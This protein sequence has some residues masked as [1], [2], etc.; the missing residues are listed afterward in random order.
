MTSPLNTA[1]V[2]AT[3]TIAGVRYSYSQGVTAE[4]WNNGGDDFRD[5]VRAGARS[6][7]GQ[8]LAEQLPVTL[9]DPGQEPPTD[10]QPPQPGYLEVTRKLGHGLIVNTAP[11]RIS[12][13]LSV[14]PE[15]CSSWGLNIEG[16]DMLN[17]A[18]QVLYRVTGYDPDTKALIL[19]LVE[20]WRYTPPTPA[21]APETTPCT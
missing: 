15:L 11:P 4:A 16:D 8:H 5:L 3:I 17:V 19:D 20:D 1:A 12:L 14:L 18:E 9:T 6:A 13:A 2:T 7:L 10:D 21:T